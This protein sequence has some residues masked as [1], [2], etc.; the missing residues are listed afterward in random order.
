MSTRQ[1]AAMLL[2]TGSIIFLVG[3]AIGV[4]RVFT[5]PDP[6][7]RLRL[8]LNHVTAWRASQPLYAFGALVAAAGVGCLV[9]TSGTPVSRGLY[10]AACA[11]LALGA[12]P[13]AW[14][15]YQ[16]GRL[17][18][19]F[20]YRQL[21]GWPFATYV[22]LTIAGLALLGIG[23]LSASAP[24]WL[25]WL[26][27]GADIAFLIGYVSFKDIPPFVFFLLFTLIGAV[28]ARRGDLR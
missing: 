2:I 18:Y 21:P 12:L 6:E 3:A 22:L 9:P 8:L 1:I 23:L 15:T 10:A 14:A 17:V 19:D 16:R 28:L 7:V 25:G 11:A 20:A 5:E 4:P 27:I 13:W 24:A 26:T